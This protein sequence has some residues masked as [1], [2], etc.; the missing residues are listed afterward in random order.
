MFYK[1][2]FDPKTII[3]VLEVQSSYP[4]EKDCYKIRISQG[5]EFSQEM[6]YVPKSQVDLA[7]HF[8]VKGMR[9]TKAVIGYLEEMWDQ[10]YLEGSANES[11]SNSEDI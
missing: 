7:V 4:H 5:V 6:E 9:P 3:Q 2:L 1:I 10:A 8:K 11:M